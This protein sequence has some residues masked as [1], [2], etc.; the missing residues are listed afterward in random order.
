MY[1]KLYHILRTGGH[2]PHPVTCV[3]ATH[4]SE[5]PF[6]IHAKLWSAHDRRRVRNNISCNVTFQPC[7]EV[8]LKYHY[9]SGF[10]FH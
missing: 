2:F 1:H 8:Q 5:M 4:L 7:K 6:S 9:N 10:S 3:E